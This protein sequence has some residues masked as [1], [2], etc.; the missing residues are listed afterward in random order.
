M[1]LRP[2]QAFAAMTASRSEQSPSLQTV[3][4]SCVVVTVN[5]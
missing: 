5:S 2:G 1:R 3:A 4:R